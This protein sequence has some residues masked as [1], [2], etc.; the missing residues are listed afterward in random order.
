MSVWST[1]CVGFFID[2]LEGVQRLGM[3]FLFASQVLTDLNSFMEYQKHRGRHDGRMTQIR[4]WLQFVLKKLICFV[5]GV[6]AF[7]FKVRVAYQNIHK[8][9]SSSC[10]VQ[11]FDDCVG[12][13]LLQHLASGP[14][15]LPREAVWP[16]S[17]SNRTVAN[18]CVLSNISILWLGGRY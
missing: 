1:S 18:L 9:G 14:F 7:L 10:F 17:Q 16:Y 13:T 8:D 2:T 15:V 4:L 11:L 12:E 6:D 3:S 5:V